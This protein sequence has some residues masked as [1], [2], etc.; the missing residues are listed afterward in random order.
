MLNKNNIFWFEEGR[1]KSLQRISNVL[2]NKEYLDG[3][4]KI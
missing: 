3:K 1:K 4:H 2:N